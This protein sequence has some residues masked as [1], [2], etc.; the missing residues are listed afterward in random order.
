M[1]MFKEATRTISLPHFHYE[2]RVILTDNMQQSVWNRDLDFDVSRW[3]AGHLS[4]EDESHS[5]VF[6]PLQPTMEEISHEVLHALWKIMRWIGAE[7]EEEVMAYHQGY[8]SGEIFTMA[9]GQ[10]PPKRSRKRK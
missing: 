4:Y 9:Y 8:L 2:V 6:L 3:A 10:F 1:A 7:F 5:F